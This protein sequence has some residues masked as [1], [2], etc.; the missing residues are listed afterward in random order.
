MLKYPPVH[1]KKEALSVKA[2]FD[3]ILGSLRVERL[4]R[5]EERFADLSRGSSILDLR[6][7]PF[8][9]KDSII[10]SFSLMKNGPA[11]RS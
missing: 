5:I 7:A 4:E 8:L 6:L 1:P 9:S 10:R 2:L 3:V 11:E